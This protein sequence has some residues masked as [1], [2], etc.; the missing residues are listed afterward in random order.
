MDDKEE[1]TMALQTSNTMIT[2]ENGQAEPFSREKLISFIRRMTSD[3]PHLR[4]DDYTERIIRLIE[5]K[6]VMSVEQLFHYLILDG[7]SYLS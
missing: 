5:H 7:L 6:K 3:F 4:T 2:K 1:K